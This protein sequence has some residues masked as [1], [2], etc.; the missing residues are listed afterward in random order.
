[1]LYAVN[2]K[3]VF[4]CKFIILILL[5]VVCECVCTYVH[6]CRLLDSMGVVTSLS[7]LEAMVRSFGGGLSLMCPLRLLPLGHEGNICGGGPTE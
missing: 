2:R 1:M 7:L 5:P 4:V 3:G 6:V